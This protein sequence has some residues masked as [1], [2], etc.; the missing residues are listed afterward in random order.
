MNKL[1]EEERKRIRFGIPRID[2]G[3]ELIIENLYS[4]V[5]DMLS[6]DDPKYRKY[7]DIA[8]LPVTQILSVSPAP[9]F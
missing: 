7:L 8:T 3:R 4:R 6:P 9:D 1:T 5:M 2:Q